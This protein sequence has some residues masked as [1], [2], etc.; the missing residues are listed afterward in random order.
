M[1]LRWLLRRSVGGP[2]KL[3]TVSGNRIEIADVKCTLHCR[4]ADL[5]QGPGCTTNER[6]NGNHTNHK[7]HALMRFNKGNRDHNNCFVS[8]G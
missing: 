2:Q 7:P 1:V 8:A 5:M 4:T 6:R 3:E